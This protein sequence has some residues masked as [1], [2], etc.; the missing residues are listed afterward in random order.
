MELKV[1][2]L[3]HLASKPTYLGNPLHGVERIT[4]TVEG[5]KGLSS[6]NPLH[7]VERTPTGSH[8]RFGLKYKNPLHGVERQ[9]FLDS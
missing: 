4:S 9:V 1:L 7:G 3:L 5:L 8:C 6:K 2:Q